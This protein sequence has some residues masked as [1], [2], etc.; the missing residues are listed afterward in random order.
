MKQKAKKTTAK[1]TKATKPPTA[2]KTTAKTPPPGPG[3]IQIVTNATKN[4][5]TNVKAEIVGE[6]F[7]LHVP[8]DN[9]IAGLPKKGWDLTHVPTGMRIAHYRNHLTARYVAAE[10]RKLGDAKVWQFTKVAESPKRVAAFRPRLLELTVDAQ[11]EQE[12]KAQPKAPATNQPVAR[13]TDRLAGP[14]T[15]KT[16]VAACSTANGKHIW[17]E[18]TSLGDYVCVVCKITCPTRI[19][20]ALKAVATRRRNDAAAQASA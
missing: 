18:P 20:A 9:G 8:W 6:F 13:P 5:R 3:E 10:L 15:I 14:R 4:E 7:A 2:K 19:A 1:K 12:R 17:S 11:A 16:Q